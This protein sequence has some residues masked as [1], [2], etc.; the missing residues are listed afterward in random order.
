M[1]RDR[2]TQSSLA[3]QLWLCDAQYDTIAVLDHV[4]KTSFCPKRVV[5]QYRDMATGRDKRLFVATGHADWIH[6][7]VGWRTLT[8][9]CEFRYRPP[10]RGGGGLEW[11]G[12]ENRRRGS[13]PIHDF[14]SL[15][16]QCTS[17]SEV[18]EFAGLFRRLVTGVECELGW[19]SSWEEK[20]EM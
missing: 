13:R 4:R 18:E 16:I 11:D 6:A 17:E 20:L 2:A 19:L 12:R 5:S 8:T 10:E 3:F 14:F 1:S 9:G 15:I 7:V